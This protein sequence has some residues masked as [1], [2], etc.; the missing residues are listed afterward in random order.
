MVTAPPPPFAFPTL[1]LDELTEMVVKWWSVVMMW[2]CGDHG[3]DVVGIESREN[4]RTRVVTRVRNVV[5]ARFGFFF[6]F[7]VFGGVGGWWREKWGER[8]FKS[9]LEFFVI[10]GANEGTG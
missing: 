3:W 4:E 8:E 9:C 6:W 7:F 5:R 2:R 1:P 10:P